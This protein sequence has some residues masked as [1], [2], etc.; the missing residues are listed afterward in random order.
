MD[1]C[2]QFVDSHRSFDPEVALQFFV[3]FSGVTKKTPRERIRTAVAEELLD[4][5]TRARAALAELPS[6]SEPSPL[7]GE[8]TS[9]LSSAIEAGAAWDPA[10][11]AVPS[12]VCFPSEALE[13]IRARAAG[14]DAPLVTILDRFIE[15]HRALE[16]RLQWLMN[17]TSVGQVARL[18]PLNDC[19]RILH[20]V[21]STFRV[22]SRVLE[23]LS[24]NR[25]AQSATVSLFFRGTKEAENNGVSRFY[26]T[27]SLLANFFEWGEDSK[28]GREAA[29]RLRQIHGRYYIPNDGMKYVLLETAFTWLDGAERIGHRPLLDVEKH[30]YFHAFVNLGLATNIGALSHDYDEMYGWYRD[31]NRANADF[32]PIKKQTFETL[33]GNSMRTFEMPQLKGMMFTAATVAMDDTYLSAVGYRAA[34]PVETKAVKAVFFTLGSFVE[35]MPYTPFLRSLQNNP[36]RGA[37]TQPGQLG[38]DARSPHMPVADASKPNGGFPEYQ[39]PILETADIRPMDLPLLTWDEIRTHTTEASLW[40]V[41]D[42]EVYDLTTWAARHPG[43]LNV[44]LEVAGQDG[45]AAFMAAGHNAAIQVFKLN[46]RIGRVAPVAAPRRAAAL[47]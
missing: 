4:L 9:V 26:D 18:D 16:R 11:G 44:L 38:V 23:L 37:Y 8:A 7:M 39:R 10:G 20:S 40:T 24:I 35:G 6:A 19:D 15:K 14:A 12:G 46:Y 21:A 32:Q 29:E 36:A 17:G 43:G 34:T 41:I 31:F 5:T 25:I 30:G 3:K 47:A 28:R 13:A 27:W 1:S 45:T 33:V 42:G 22:E 2:L